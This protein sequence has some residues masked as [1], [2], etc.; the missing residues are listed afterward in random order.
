[1]ARFAQLPRATG[2]EALALLG[3]V[4]EAVGLTGDLLVPP[5]EMFLRRWVET[6]NIAAV[7]RKMGKSRS[8]LLRDYRPRVVTVVTDVY[9]RLPAMAT[10]TGEASARAA[11]APDATVKRRLGPMPD[12]PRQ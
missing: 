10:D 11:G 2:G 7:A 9:M 8:H 12:C 1:M 6:G 5:G 4:E 3:L